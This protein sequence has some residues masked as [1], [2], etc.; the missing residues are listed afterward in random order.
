LERGQGR[1]LIRADF[2]AGVITRFTPASLGPHWEKIH[3][4]AAYRLDE[5]LARAAVPFTITST[6]RTPNAN[7]AAA[8]SA[9]SR[10]LPDAAGL[11]NAF[12]VWLR[13]PA[14]FTRDRAQELMR[15]ARAAGFNGVG[16]YKGKPLIHV[17]VRPSPWSW[18]GEKIQTADGKQTM[19]FYPRNEIFDVLTGSA[20]VVGVAIFA[21]ALF[22][23]GRRHS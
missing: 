3:A 21:L 9:S 16:F 11:S 5:F 23:F 19:R 4:L 12:D 6:Y 7:T 13:D 18:L 20:G 22:F 2:G 8:G 10:H 17:D 15:L 1:G 14:F